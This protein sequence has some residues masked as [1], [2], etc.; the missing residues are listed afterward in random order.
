MVMLGGLEEIIT[1]SLSSLLHS[2]RSGLHSR[3]AWERLSLTGAGGGS[4]DDNKLPLAW[5]PPASHPALQCS[6][7]AKQ[8]TDLSQVSDSQ[9]PQ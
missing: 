6:N 9:S 7:N 3:L 8:T 1:P 5:P 4:A 2:L